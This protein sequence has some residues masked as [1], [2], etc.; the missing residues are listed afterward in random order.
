[1]SLPKWL[2]RAVKD[3]VLSR[4]EAKRIAE[5]EEQSRVVE[6]PP[7]LDPVMER[8]YLWEMPCRTTLH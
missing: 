1:M 3:K 4:E 2:R 7:E 5:L 8:L 6:M